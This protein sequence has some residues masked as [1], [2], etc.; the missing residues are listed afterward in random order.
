MSS[1]NTK[2]NRLDAIAKAGGDKARRAFDWTGRAVIKVLDAKTG[3]WRILTVVARNDVVTVNG[4]QAVDHRLD[5]VSERREPV[6]KR[7][8]D[9]VQRSLDRANT[10]LFMDH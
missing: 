1:I 2:Q 6:G 7:R 9:L 8:G 3:E 10:A 5:L 4:M